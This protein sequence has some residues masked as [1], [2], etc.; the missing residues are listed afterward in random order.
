MTGQGVDTDHRYKALVYFQ[1]VHIELAQIA[2]ARVACA[3]IVDGDHDT[4]LMELFEE[5]PGDVCWLDQLALSQL[6]NKRDFA[7]W[8]CAKK[9]PAVFNQ[10][11]VMAVAGGDVDTDMEA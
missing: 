11:Q 6:Q 9:L 10:L 3:E 4:Q 2:Q 7:G 5:L 1:E 8:E